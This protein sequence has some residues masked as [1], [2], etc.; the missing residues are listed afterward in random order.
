V[1]LQPLFNNPHASVV[2]EAAC[3]CLTSES[4]FEAFLLQGKYQDFMLTGM[5]DLEGN[6]KC[7]LL[8]RIND[9]GDGYYLS[10]DLFKGIGQFRAWAHRPDGDGEEAFHYEQLQ[11]AHYVPNNGTHQFSLLA[12][13][14]YLEFSLDGYVL[15]TLADDQFERGKVGFYVESATMRIDNLRIEL[16][17]GSQTG[18]YPDGVPNY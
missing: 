8:L 15:L 2:A 9:E 11:A 13:E 17:D 5:L 7:G 14:Q 12:Y 4:G 10:L 18:S 3:C 1:P 16:C 6:G